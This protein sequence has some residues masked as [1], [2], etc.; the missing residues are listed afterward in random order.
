MTIASDVSVDRERLEKFIDTSRMSDEEIK[1]FIKYLETN[2]NGG[3][4]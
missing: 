2:W 1:Q 3:E 4:F